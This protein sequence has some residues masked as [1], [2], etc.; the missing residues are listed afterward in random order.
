MFGAGQ[1]TFVDLSP[2]SAYAVQTKS[3]TGCSA[4]IN[5]TSPGL[6]YDSKR[7]I[8]IGWDDG[9][10]LYTFDSEAGVCTPHTASGGPRRGSVPG[11]WGRLAY[12]PDF[13][14]VVLVNDWDQDAFLFRLSP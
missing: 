3:L 9:D 11:S 13:D 1:Y 6:T 4:L 5:A 14:A 8:V 2:G 7:K 12:A 10:T